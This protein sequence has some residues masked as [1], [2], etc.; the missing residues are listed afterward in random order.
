[1]LA[2]VLTLEKAGAPPDPG[3]LHIIGL[4]GTAAMVCVCAPSQCLGF[5]SCTLNGQNQHRM[6]LNLWRG[7]Y[8][9]N[10]GFQLFPFLVCSEMCSAY[11]GT[12]LVRDLNMYN[13]FPLF[14]SYLKLRNM[15]N[16]AVILL[17]FLVFSFKQKMSDSGFFLH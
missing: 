8:L 11:T 10:C 6:G 14:T 12:V 13:I 16:V 4:A 3:V 17:H 15:V 1:M 2:C 9:W 7:M 5:D